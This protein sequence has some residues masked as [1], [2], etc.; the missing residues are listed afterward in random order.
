M[1]LWI[2]PG[3]LLVNAFFSTSNTPDDKESFLNRPNEMLEHAEKKLVGEPTR[4]DLVDCVSNLKRAIVHRR[5]A[6][7]KIYQF[8]KIQIVGI[9]TGNWQRL[10]TFDVIRP[11]MFN[12]LKKIRD[13]I[14]HQD[15]TPPNLD[16]CR[17]YAEYVWYFLR[18][19][20]RLVTRVP[21]YIEANFSIKDRP[22][23]Y[24]VY[25]DIGPNKG[26]E[27]SVRG[28]L[29]PSLVSNTENPEWL[30]LECQEIKTAE[31]QRK[32]GAVKT[33]SKK[34]GEV[35]ISYISDASDDHLPDDIYFSGVATGPAPIVA[36]I[37]KGYFDL[38]REE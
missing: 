14:E 19:T 36:Q 38:I 9:G 21:D 2:H 5:D 22:A 25:T 28:W 10:L 18:S 12:Q 33:K 31:D 1:K 29:P 37:I 32:K 13:V 6:L 3:S 7:Q 8:N 15:G 30:N 34:K 27:I 20:D 23:E 26:W 11:I 17:E 4:Q 16:R 24:S 35:N